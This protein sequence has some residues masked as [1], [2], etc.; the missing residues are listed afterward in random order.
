MIP[1]P[2][3]ILENLTAIAN[4]WRALAGAW[5]VLVGVPVV[6]VVRARLTRYKPGRK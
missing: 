2:V 5:H 4:D 3:A 1:S 6:A